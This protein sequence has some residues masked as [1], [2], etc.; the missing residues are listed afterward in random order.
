M[1]AY[2]NRRR[3]VKPKPQIVSSRLQPYV[4]TRAQASRFTARRAAR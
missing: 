2:A 1:I 4:V 3:V